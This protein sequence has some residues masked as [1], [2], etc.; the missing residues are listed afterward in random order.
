MQIIWKFLREELVVASEPNTRVIISA[1]SAWSFLLA[2]I[3]KWNISS[4]AWKE[5]IWYLGNLLTK[6]NQSGLRIVAAET[7]AH[8]VELNVIGKFSVSALDKYDNLT[9]KSNGG[10]ICKQITKTMMGQVKNV[11]LEMSR[12]DL[13][14]KDLIIEHHSLS[15]DIVAFLKRGCCP[16]T[17]IQIGRDVLP[18]SKWSQLIQV[19]FIKRF[20][21]TPF[22]QYVEKNELFQDFYD[23]TPKV[24]QHQPELYIS[25]NEESGIRYVYQPEISPKNPHYKRICISSNSVLNKN[26]TQLLKKQRILST[27]KNVGYYSASYENEE[28]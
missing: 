7:L 3:D 2:S 22:V 13:S 25:S 4:K 11:I 19:D 9:C 28:C 14:E 18:I 24:E 21:G 17:S 8:I 26:K 20:L 12:S 5:S 10:S 15:T 27:A 23:F 1:I 16:E 6:S